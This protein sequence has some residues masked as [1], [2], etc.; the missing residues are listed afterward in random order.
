MIRLA[1]KYQIEDVQKQA[2]A[3]LRIS[4]PPDWQAWERRDT[5]RVIAAAAVSSAIEVMYLARLV[6]E[7]K[8][9]PSAFYT[10]S[11]AGGL[12]VDGWRREDGSV[13]TL[14]NDDLK[15]VINGY[16]GLR[17]RAPLMLSRVFDVDPALGSIRAPGHCHGPLTRAYLQ[18]AKVCKLMGFKLLHSWKGVINQWA[19]KYV[20]CEACAKVL[21][22]R[23]AVERRALWDILPAMFGLKMDGWVAAPPPQ[24][25]W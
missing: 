25:T 13:Q 11:L 15:R 20:F 21:E 8:M 1:H 17:Q 2:V 16:G 9:L 6:D 4:Y 12:I 19:T 23:S 3:A 22:E 24:T 7:P 10:C 14:A 18:E 5:Q